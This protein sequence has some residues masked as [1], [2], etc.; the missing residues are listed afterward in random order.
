M[1]NGRGYS[2]PFDEDQDKK[3]ALLLTRRSSGVTLEMIP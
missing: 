2:L 1:F 3:A